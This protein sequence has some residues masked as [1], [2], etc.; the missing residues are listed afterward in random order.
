LPRG[1]VALAYADPAF[2]QLQDGRAVTGLD[3]AVTGGFAKVIDFAPVPKAQHP[4][5]M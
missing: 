1:V 2:A 4:V 5:A 3:K